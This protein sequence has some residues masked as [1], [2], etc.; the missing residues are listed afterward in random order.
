VVTPADV[1]ARPAAPN[2]RAL[3]EGLFQFYAY[4]FT[5]FMDPD[6][7]GF[8]FDAA[9]RLPAYGHLDSYWRD[10]DRWPHVIRVGERV[11]GFAL[12]NAVSPSGRGVDRN[13]GEFFVARRFRRTGVGAAAVHAVFS[14][15]PGGWE[16]A[17]AARNTPAQD[18]WPRAI[19]T[20]PG[21]H[22]LTRIEGDGERWRGPIWRFRV[23]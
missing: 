5:D 17:V 15:Q 4:D 20:A 1:S 23:G 2:E 10:A 6:A 18:F 19:E 14:Q 11:A 9:G 7:R 13:M 16:V 3:I 8:E 12:V 21:A 22:D